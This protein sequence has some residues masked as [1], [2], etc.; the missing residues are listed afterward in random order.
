VLTL[1][2]ILQQSRI[3][4]VI[5]IDKIEH[6]IPLANTLVEYGFNVLEITLRTDC[7]L[8]AIKQ[9]A[10]NVPKAIVG[11]G[12]IITPGQLSLAKVAGAQ[13]AVSPGLSKQL[14]T[15]AK[16]E[17]LSYLPGIAT[18]SEALFAYELGLTQLKFFP[19]EMMGGIKML[20]AISEVLPSLRFCPTG[21]INSGNFIN[22]L[23]LSLIPCIGGTWIAPRSLIEKGN[24]AEIASHAKEAKKQLHTVFN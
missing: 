17:K 12:T 7:A 16:K 9:I 20:S 18:V 19:A 24:F 21:G 2:D 14:V 13:F 8:D 10:D 5:V 11:A 3:I 6:A 4:P 23:K 1:I 15:E 22:Y